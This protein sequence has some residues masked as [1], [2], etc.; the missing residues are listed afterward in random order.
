M[1]I[2]TYSTHKITQKPQSLK[3]Q[4]SSGN[5]GYLA[6]DSSFHSVILPSNT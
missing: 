5:P 3:T 2:Y 6:T 4:V 1:Y